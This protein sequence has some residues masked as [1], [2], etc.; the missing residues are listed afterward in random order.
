MKL[1]KKLGL[2][3][4]NI[5]TPIKLANYFQDKIYAWVSPYLIGLKAV[6]GQTAW[7][8]RTSYGL[9]KKNMTIFLIG[10][11]ITFDAGGISIKPANNMHLM[12]FDMLGA[13]TV[14][15]VGEALKRYKGTL[16]ILGCCAENSF[17]HDCTRPGDVLTYPDK[18][19]VEIIN[20]DAEGRLVLADGILEAK[21]FNPDLIIT[22]AT[23]TGAAKYCLG[24]ATAIFSNRDSLAKTFVDTSTS[25][26]ELAWHLPIWDIHRKAIKGQK[27][28][29]DIRNCSDVAPAS[30][31]AAFLEHFVGPD[32]PWLHLDIAGS[33]YKNEVPTGA[34]YKSL[35]KFIKEY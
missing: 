10:K 25:C 31:A 24:E 12:K 8:G 9:K 27:G 34:M 30:T 6:G 29:S 26:G 19:T 3:P 33:A 28:V 13:A 22:V 14:L 32:I 11:G 35:I 20:T 23:L 5:L 21:N 7:M 4:P 1:I 17:R 18:T 2:M 16:E 15:A